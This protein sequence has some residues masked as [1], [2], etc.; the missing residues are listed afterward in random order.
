[1]K[2]RVL[3][4]ANMT[5]GT[6]LAKNRLLS[7]IES[8]A[9]NDLEVTVYPL[10]P[11]SGLTSEQIIKDTRFDYDAVVCCGG[12]GTLNHL[13]NSLYKNDLDVSIGYF[14]TGS[15]NDFASSLFSSR[16]VEVS[17][18][19]EAIRNEHVFCYDIGRFN[20][21]YFNYVAAFGAFTKVSYSTEQSFKNAFGYLAYILNALTI[22]PEELA[23]STHLKLETE[24]ETIE[25]DFLI[26]AISNTTSVA[27]MQ[28]TVISSSKL[29]DGLFEVTLVSSIDNIAKA[30]EVVGTLLSGKPDG[31]NVIHF[32]C[33]KMKI[34]FDKP[35]AWTL[36]GEN[37]GFHQHVDFCVLP[38]KQRIYLP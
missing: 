20:D 9:T 5:S 2:K 8:F 26:G 17:R 1:M 4:L 22:V 21:S 3:L 13:I 16:N 29:D 38:Q 18:L 25:G 11:E 10:I 32:N 19:A 27:G 36:D 23:E 24:D 12:D 6:G 28:S 34:E 31:T 15:T 7:I 35:V 14:P 33:R 30:T 37:G